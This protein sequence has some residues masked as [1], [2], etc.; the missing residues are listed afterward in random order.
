MLLDW[1]IAGFSYP[2]I[3]CVEN[4][5]VEISREHT[6]GFRASIRLLLGHCDAAWSTPRPRLDRCSAGAEG[7]HAT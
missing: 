2:P 1:V 6:A 5:S 7:S 3:V 4:R